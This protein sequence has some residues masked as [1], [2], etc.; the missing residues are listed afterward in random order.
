MKR[1]YMIRRLTKDGFDP[2]FLMSDGRIG[3][4]KKG[5][6][7]KYEFFDNVTQ[8]YRYCYDGEYRK[9]SVD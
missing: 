3:V 8:A 9:T 7:T 4:R 6:F 2:T 1:S 5:P